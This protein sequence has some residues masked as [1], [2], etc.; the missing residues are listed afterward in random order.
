MKIRVLRHRTQRM[1]SNVGRAY[2]P[3]CERE[4]DML[5][6]LQSATLLETDLAN[7]N[8]LLAAGRLHVVTM[9]S[10]NLCICGDSLTA[11]IASDVSEH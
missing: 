11:L 4:V 7:F 2:C 8:H 3:V 6:A 5:G 9:T 10:G 1:P